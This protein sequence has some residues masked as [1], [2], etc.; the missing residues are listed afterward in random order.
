[1]ISSNPET[2]TT[3]NNPST[4]VFSTGDKTIPCWSHTFNVLNFIMYFDHDVNK[5]LRCPFESLCGS[6]SS[7]FAQCSSP[8]PMLSCSPGAKEAHALLQNFSPH[9]RRRQ[10]KFCFFLEM[11]ITNGYKCGV[12]FIEILFLSVTAFVPRKQ[13][14]FE[15]AV[16]YPIKSDLLDCV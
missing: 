10:K 5:I 3:K 9:E 16:S 12:M 8:A 14:L 2:P 6:L 13:G 7:A 4:C 11:P 1:M 15:E